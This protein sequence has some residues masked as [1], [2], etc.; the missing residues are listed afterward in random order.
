MKNAIKPIAYSG[1][2]INV[3]N[4]DYSLMPEVPQGGCKGCDLLGKGLCT[5]TITDYCRQ[6]Y[7]L[8]K[9]ALTW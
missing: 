5:K 2:Y 7:I 4:R 1:K 9:V 8:K 6:G 3:N